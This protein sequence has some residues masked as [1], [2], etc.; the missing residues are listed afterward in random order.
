MRLTIGMKIFSIAAVILLLMIATAVVSIQLI[1]EVSE[2]LDMV[3]T[4]HIPVSERIGLIEVKILEQS[5]VLQR[6]FVS[7]ED[8]VRNLGDIRI[9]RRR[10]VTSDQEIRNEFD[11][12]L[13]LVRKEAREAPL[14]PQLTRMRSEYDSYFELSEMLAEGLLAGDRESFRVLLPEL[15][16]AQDAINRE[17][18]SIRE[19]LKNLLR[20]S[21]DT[22]YQNKKS[23]L[24]VN[25][26][27]TVIAAVFGLLFGALVTKGLLRSVSNL[28][29]GTRAVEN[30][31]LD[32][33][34][35]VL[36]QD[37]VGYLTGTF[38]HMIGELRLKERIKDTFGKYMDPRI[39]TNLLDQPEISEPGGER[40][41][42]TVMFINLKGFTS[43]SEILEPNDL[44]QIINR[45][46]NHMTKAISSHDGVV[47][48][49]MGDA[50]M[51]YWGPPFTK[52]NDHPTL[53]CKAAI[54]AIRKLDELQRDLEEIIGDQAANIDIDVR[55]GISTGKMIVGIVGSDISR[56][57]TIIGDPVNL[58]SRLEDANKVF[59]THILVA[60][61][62]RSKVS[63]LTFR[64]VDYMQ[65]K[66]KTE[67]IRV[68]E[69]LSDTNIDAAAITKF[70]KGL[71]HYRAS[72]WHEAEQEF[73]GV[74]A[75]LP[76]D[77]P[78]KEYLERIK[79]YRL[80][81]PA[82]GWDGVW[83]LET[84]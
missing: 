9:E 39:V 5:I 59:G 77:A 28:V 55:I 36:S 1:S 74:L 33:E 83:T 19:A 69:L 45:F 78:S 53:A 71:R 29:D 63:E 76:D 4:R 67:P 12:L 48:K 38:N 70:E 62:T 14:S 13:R 6:L 68:Y 60:D 16:A 43:I 41:E 35:S 73:N 65:V 3:A 10:L 22:A 27:L 64:E 37:E 57:F 66:G 42:M 25:V 49:F 20:T 2:E 8:R 52:E 11:G 23:A 44:V 26:I 30:G 32:T 50:V 7:A 15:N 61:H 82:A 17:L 34:V 80:D 72:E 47:D 81:P 40:R 56:N 24:N 79:Y 21:A 54:E 18:E 46:F 84:K 75:D 31:K 58:G 51:A